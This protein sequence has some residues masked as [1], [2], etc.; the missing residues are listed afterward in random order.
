[1]ETEK[2]SI[3]LGSK[4]MRQP[5]RQDGGPGPESG[6]GAETKERGGDKEKGE[7]D[8]AAPN[9]IMQWAGS[10]NWGR[11][12]AGRDGMFCFYLSAGEVMR[13][14]ASLE[15]NSGAGPQYRPTSER[16]THT[17]VDMAAVC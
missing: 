16:H 6:G 9:V 11:G 8:S 17:G 4:V 7:R 12:G 13:Q 15:P 1:M 5:C 10:A 2:C 3:A 14:R